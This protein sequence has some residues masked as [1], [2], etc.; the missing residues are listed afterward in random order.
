MTSG[1]PENSCAVPASVGHDK[2]HPPANHAEPWIRLIVVVVVTAV[3]AVVTLYSTFNGQ[4]AP[5]E[6]SAL[7]LLV[8]GYLFGTDLGQRARRWLER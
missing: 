4:G 7:M 3:W 1:D 8:A 6:L 2:R 5:V